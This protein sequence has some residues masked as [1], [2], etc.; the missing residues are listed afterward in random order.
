[1]TPKEEQTWIDNLAPTRKERLAILQDLLRHANADNMSK[2]DRAI[3][4]R[5][6][7]LL[8]ARRSSLSTSQDIG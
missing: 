7:A 8:E 5:Q 4:I 2:D 1:M 6:L 3:C